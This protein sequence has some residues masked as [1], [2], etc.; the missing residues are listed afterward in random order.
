M[1][2]YVF[3]FYI[4][5]LY[6]IY[7][8]WAIRAASKNILTKILSLFGPNVN[9]NAIDCLPVGLTRGLPVALAK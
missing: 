5:M 7:P 3:I 8:T 4:P 6:N 9:L 1:C 2:V